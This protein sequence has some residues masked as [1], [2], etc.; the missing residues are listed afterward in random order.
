MLVI[1]YLYLFVCLFITDFQEDDNAINCALLINASLFKVAFSILHVL[2]CPFNSLYFLIKYSFCLLK[3][4]SSFIYIQKRRKCYKINKKAMHAHIS[5]FVTYICFFLH[6][7]S[8][9][10]NQ[11]SK[12]DFLPFQLQAR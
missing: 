8:H 11:G 2:R 5:K 6:F 4:C 10:Y 1:I 9:R 7:L 12:K 3:T